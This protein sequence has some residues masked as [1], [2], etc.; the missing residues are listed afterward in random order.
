MGSAA[1]KLRAAM[2]AVHMVSHLGRLKIVG[3]K[4]C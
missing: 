1:H 2:A 4:T 3:Y